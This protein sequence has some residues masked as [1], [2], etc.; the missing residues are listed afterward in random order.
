MTTSI[1]THSHSHSQLYVVPDV[2]LEI[3]SDSSHA[4]VDGLLQLT[5]MVTL[6]GGSLVNR[7]FIIEWLNGSTSLL[8]EQ[9]EGE[10]TLVSDLS[11]NSMNHSLR[12][13]NVQTHHSGSYLCRVEMEGVLFEESVYVHIESKY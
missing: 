9:M 3:L 6:H 2:T 1:L 13:R 8:Q 5:C 11:S 7:N 4:I 10:F 12:I